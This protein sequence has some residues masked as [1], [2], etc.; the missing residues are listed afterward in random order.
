M[1]W[2]AFLILLFC[3]LLHQQLAAQIQETA[4]K[5]SKK[6]LKSDFF[7]PATDPIGMMQSDGSFLLTISE[8]LLSKALKKVIPDIGIIQKVV[9]Q[10]INKGDFIVFECRKV[11]TLEQSLY[12]A[13][14]LKKSEN[15]Q[16]YIEAGYNTCSGSPC[17]NCKFSANGCICE[18]QA[19]ADNPTQIG[20]CNHTMSSK[21][22]LAKIPVVQ[23]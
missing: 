12:I 8:S 17:S 22:A 2:K 4:P 5:I 19:P 16:I 10:K 18:E 23:E 15:G 9:K 11:D 3:T 21:V 1:Y 14:P 20:R 7:D 13:I 6:A